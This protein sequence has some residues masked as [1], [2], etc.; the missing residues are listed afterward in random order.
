[1][2]DPQDMRNMGGLWN[3]M[4]TTSIVYILGALALAGIVPL[5]GFWS[6]DEILLE[7]S[8]LSP[9]A[10]VLLLVAAGFTAFYMTRQVIMIFFGR[11]KS[12]AAAHAAESPKVMTVPLMILAF[13]SVTVGL[14]NA[15]PLGLSLFS[16]WLEGE[17]HGA[18]DWGIAIGSTV[19]ALAAIGLGYR[20]YR[21]RPQVEGALD[22]PLR[23]TGLIFKTLNAK[24]KIDEIYG[25][26][27]I[28]P[29][30]RLARFLAEVIDG[31]FWH[32]FFHDVILA[33]TFV[34][35]AQVISFP[36]DKGIVDRF[37][38]GIAHGVGAAAKSLRR[39]QTGYVRNYAL[40]VLL[41]VVAIVA[42]FAF[43]VLGQ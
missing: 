15:A 11:P 35:G 40:V 27:F 24:Y 21:P 36:I 10:F 19:L 3:K 42:W 22:D 25:F 6:K 34:T 8:H 18:F 32:D 12:E 26:L 17:A 29:F 20:V 7:A 9:V 31:R 41:G 4:R 16:E 28:R 5:A 1:P 43:R 33:R 39:V 37:F 23:K 13:F 30:E 2:F 14:I 38:D